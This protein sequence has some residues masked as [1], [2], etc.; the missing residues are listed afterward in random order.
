MW[1]KLW[2]SSRG[3]WLAFI[4]RLVSI[5]FLVP[6]G[7][8]EEAFLKGRWR[9]VQ[10]FY[11]VVTDNPSVVRVICRVI[12]FYWCYCYWHFQSLRFYN[13]FSKEGN[14]IF[15]F[16][17]SPATIYFPETLLCVSLSWLSSSPHHLPG[18][19][20]PDSISVSPFFIQILSL[21]GLLSPLTAWLTW[22]LHICL[23]D[24]FPEALLH[25]TSCFFCPN[26]YLCLFWRSTTNELVAEASRLNT[27][28]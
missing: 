1:E 25:P 12:L 8:L 15:E 27:Q 28:S 6:N 10:A 19:T 20:S 22:W 13:L 18:G 23:V 26:F 24:G 4:T 9:E 2:T 3:R 5:E 17:I 21:S 7:K 16:Y 11:L 14:S